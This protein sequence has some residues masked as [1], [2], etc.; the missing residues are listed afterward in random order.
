MK[1]LFYLFLVLGLFACSSDSE[2]DDYDETDPCINQPILVTNE[3]INISGLTA[4]VSGTIIAEDCSNPNSSDQGFVYSTNPT[5]TINNNLINVL[6]QNISTTIQDLDYDTTYYVRT[7]LINAIGNPLYGN[8]IS[9]STENY[10]TPIYLDENGITIKA[11]DWAEVGMSGEINGVTYTIVD[12]NMLDLMISSNED[13]TKA[14]TTKIT[15]MTHQSNY[16]SLFGSNDSDSAP[17]NFNQDISSWDVSNVTDMS[18]MF[19]YEEVFNQD[20]GNWDVSN[21]TNMEGMFQSAKNFNQDIGNWDVSSVTNMSRMFS[22][23]TLFNQDIGNW[24]VSNVADMFFMLG[25]TNYSNPSNFNQD[26]GN[27]DVSNVTTMRGMFG[28]ATAFNQDIGNWNVSNVTDMRGMFAGTTASNVT[29]YNTFNQDIGLWDV[30]NVTDMNDM[31]RANDY[32]NQDIGNW[33]VSNVTDMGGMFAG[34]TL[35]NQDIGNWDVSNV[36]YMVRMFYD[37]KNFNQDISSWDVSNVTDMNSM[38]SFTDFFNQ[39]ISSWDVSNVTDMS[40]MFVTGNHA[41]TTDGAEYSPS[42]FNQDISSWDVSNVVLCNSF[43]GQSSSWTL[44]KPDFVNCSED[45]GCN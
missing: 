15:D 33:D 42:V 34:T 12:R 45:L 7:F 21:V 37:S 13:L 41:N 22:E 10:S 25:S 31:F 32:F 24:D 6:G 26:I 36:T 14:C 19:Y 29:V 28:H 43:C 1:K 5:P 38:F 11:Y 8:E 30:S 35:F 4:D 17:Q 3:A 18:W 27:W 40:W 9:F 23:A 2:N 16:R 39:D 20:I 44:P